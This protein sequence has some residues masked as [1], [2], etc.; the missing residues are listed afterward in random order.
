MKSTSILMLLLTVFVSFPHIAESNQIIRIPNGIIE[1]CTGVLKNQNG[2]HK[3]YYQDG[4]IYI[5]TSCT[6]GLKQGL[7]YKYYP[8]G[9]IYSEATYLN[10][11]L[12]GMVKT[13]DREEKLIAPATNFDRNSAI[14]KRDVFDGNQTQYSNSPK[15]LKFS[16]Q[17]ISSRERVKQ[18][19]N[20]NLKYQ[21]YSKK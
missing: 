9:N 20:K 21:P 5:E 15:S 12:K 13:Y 7:T 17:N 6:E 16:K 2:I 1:P 10:N 8:N 11:Q 19:N 18:A 3:Q 14:L 4:S